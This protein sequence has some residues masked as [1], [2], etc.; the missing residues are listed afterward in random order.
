MVREHASI[1]LL[2]LAGS[3]ARPPTTLPMS[4]E[5]RHGTAVAHESTTDKLRKPTMTPTLLS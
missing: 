2:L 3:A 4:R 5:K 1:T